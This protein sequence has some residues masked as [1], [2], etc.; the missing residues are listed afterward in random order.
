[1]KPEIPVF[2][3]IDDAYA[4]FL[5]TALRS[6]IDNSSKNRSYRAIV[7]YQS[8]SEENRKRIASLAQAHFA[9]E[10]VPMQKG[11]ESIADRLSNRLRFDC[12]TLTIYFR[13]FIPAMFEQYDRG[14]YIDSDVV[15]LGDLAELFDTDI[16]DHYIGAC[17]DLSVL[18]VQ[19]LCEYMENVVG[20][21]AQRY[22]NSGVLLMNLKKLRQA[23]L[24]RHFLQ[25]LNRYHFDSV[26]PD[27]D[28][29][30]ALCSGKIYYLDS[31]WNTMPNEM[32]PVDREA[33][34][35]HY[36]LY[37]KPWCYDD[38][39]YSEHFWHYAKD[40]GYYGEICRIR[41]AF[42]PDKQDGLDIL[43]QRAVQISRTEKITL[44]AMQE[45]GERIR[46]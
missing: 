43:V 26:A 15:L 18:Q 10:F 46:L 21:Q 42:R 17:N 8:L 6:A 38:I 31:K 30:N 37:S 40:S 39:Q 5:A 14:I 3:S 29:L 7:L 2:F 16:G 33:K 4:P 19:P 13:L 41:Q 25:L 9:V 27:Q 12:F 1:M 34:L 44:R 32:L 22:V 20:V 45:R 36:N 28:Y 24:D 11:L 35:V 23:N